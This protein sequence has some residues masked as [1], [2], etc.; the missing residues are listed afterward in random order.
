MLSVPLCVWYVHVAEEAE[1]NTA[2]AHRPNC[3]A[4][5][6]EHLAP[7]KK[8]QRNENALVKMVQAPMTNDEEDA[9]LQNFHTKMALLQTHTSYTPSFPVR[10]PNMSDILFHLFFFSLLFLSILS[11]YM[12]QCIWS[13][14]TFMVVGICQ[15]YT[16]SRSCIHDRQCRRMH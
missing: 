10:P 1:K 11:I 5:Q 12:L 13:Y 14:T 15:Q 2:L 16:Q 3:V 8:K 4:S 6:T 7:I 9:Q